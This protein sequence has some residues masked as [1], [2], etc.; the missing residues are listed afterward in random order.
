MIKFQD[1]ISE[2]PKKD[3]KISIEAIE[4]NLIQEIYLRIIDLQRNLNLFKEKILGIK[5]VRSTK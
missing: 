3:V 4:L 1:D 5:T 2:D